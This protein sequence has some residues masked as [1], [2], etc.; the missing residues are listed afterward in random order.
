VAQVGGKAL[1]TQEEI[2]KA[3]KEI[4]EIRN[5]YGLTDKDIP[6]YVTQL[7]ASLGAG[8]EVEVLPTISEENISELT[9]IFSE[10]FS[11]DGKSLDIGELVST[12]KSL[13]I[14]DVIAE[15][16]AKGVINGVGDGEIT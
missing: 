2:D 8:V 11:I 4:S 12:L 13:G 7:E 16:I 1:L 15:E 14:P 6:D 10:I 9:T 5:K 3:N